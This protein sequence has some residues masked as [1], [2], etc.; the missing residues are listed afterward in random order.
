MIL[1]LLA[2]L[3][4]TI[5]LQDIEVRFFIVERYAWELFALLSHHH[6]YAVGSSQWPEWSQITTTHSRFPTS[7]LLLIYVQINLKIVNSSKIN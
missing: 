6:H 5:K 2:D 3:T 4:A 7:H 1:F